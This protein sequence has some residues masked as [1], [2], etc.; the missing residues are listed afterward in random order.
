MVG[1]IRHD[2]PS[3]PGVELRQPQGQVIGLAAGAGE[4]EAV[5]AGVVRGQQTLGVV[6][7]SLVQIAGVGV[8][9]CRLLLQG[10]HHV[11]VAVTQRD[12]VVIRIQVALAFSVPHPHALAAHQFH[13]VLVK[14]PVGRAQQRLAP[15]DQG[16]ATLGQAAQRGR[17]KGVDGFHGAWRSDCGG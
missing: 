17:V 3:A 11:R 6:Q 4:H 16:L 9:L 1:P 5:Q 13:R 14:Q 2:D 8:E 15:A 10:L 7:Q 12:H